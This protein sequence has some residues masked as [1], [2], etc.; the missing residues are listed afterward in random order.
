MAGA[1]SMWLVLGL[2]LG[3]ALLAVLGECPSRY[4]RAQPGHRAQVGPGAAE[5]WRRPAPK[6]QRER[7]RALP[8]GT[9]YTAG[10]VAFVL[11]KC[12][13][14]KDEIADLQEE[15]GKEESLQ[16]EQQLAHLTQQ[17]AQTEQ[18]LNNLMAQ[19]DPLFEHVTALVGTQRELLEKKLQ[20]IHQLLQDC[21]PEKGVE[22]PESEAGIP[23]PEDLRLEEKEAGDSQAWKE[24]VNWSTE[25]WNLATSRQVEQGLRRRFSKPVTE[26]LRH[27]PIQEERTTPEGLVKPSLF[28]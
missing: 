9:L 19:L 4:C 15:K 23:F 10:V 28:L 25:T 1:V 13:Q 8:W 27:S 24:P 22:A 18:H 17:L 3:S 12:L 26:G 20:T 5:P 2:L 21:T 7:A 16:S 11:Y 6:E 14:G